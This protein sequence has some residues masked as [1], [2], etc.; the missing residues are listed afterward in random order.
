MYLKLKDINLYY[1]K[2]GGGKREI[3]ILPGWGETRKTFY[4][5]IR[6]L[7]QEYTIY[8]VDYPGFGNTEF[9][10]KSLTIYDYTNLIIDF[11]NELQIWHPILIGHSFGGRI[12]ITMCGYFQ[13]KIPKII[14]IDSAGIK[15]KKTFG[16]WLKKWIYKFL[17]KMVKILPFQDKA[18]HYNR[19]IQRFG[20]TDYNNLKPNE[21]ETFRNIVNEDL[22]PYL[23]QIRSETLLIWG[24]QDIDTPLK[25]GIKMNKEIRDSGLVILEKATHFSYLEKSYLVNEIILEFLKAEEKSLS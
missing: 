20:S 25:D 8:I 5:M 2:F 6:A 11:L 14:L 4:P 1:E 17:K 9:P 23:K 21:R 15:P 12:A 18:K 22:T 7:E 13:K 16:A 10:T 3:V 19:L 24:Q